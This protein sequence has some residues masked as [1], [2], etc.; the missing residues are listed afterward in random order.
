MN[1]TIRSIGMI[2]LI[3]AIGDVF[4]IEWLKGIHKFSGGMLSFLNII[5]A[6]ILGV[7][8]YKAFEH[9]M[10][11]ENLGRWVIVILMLLDLGFSEMIYR[12]YSKL[13]DVLI[14]VL[15]KYT[16]EVGKEVNIEIPTLK[17]PAKKAK[18]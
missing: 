7:V 1:K 8:A 11:E 12:H 6:A 9:Q 14:A 5:L 10:K 2:A 15:N 13:D 4:V 16:G 18:K 17:T 3:T